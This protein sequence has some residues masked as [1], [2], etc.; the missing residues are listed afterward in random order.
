MK[1]NILLMPFLNRKMPPSRP[2]TLLNDWI[3]MERI[4]ETGEAYINWL[5]VVNSRNRIRG[6]GVRI[7]YIN[8][9]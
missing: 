1:R 5:A 6:D 4:G 7:V 9:K 3:P 8:S 2:E